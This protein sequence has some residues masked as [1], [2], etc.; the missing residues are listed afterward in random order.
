MNG[1]DFD[2]QR[3]AMVVEHTKLSGW[4]FPGMCPDEQMRVGR[5]D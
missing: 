4:Q 3:P 1:K 5:S 2:V